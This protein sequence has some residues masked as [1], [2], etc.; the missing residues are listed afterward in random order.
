MRRMVSPWKIGSV[1]ITLAPTAAASAVSRIARKHT[2]PTFSSMAT[3]A[4]FSTVCARTAAAGRFVVADEIRLERASRAAGKD[5]SSQLQPGK[6]QNFHP[7]EA[8]KIRY[9]H[10]HDAEQDRRTDRRHEYAAQRKQ[11]GDA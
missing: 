8:E 7:V 6:Q 2:V 10:A 5:A 11:R 4:L 9:T 1:R 3:R